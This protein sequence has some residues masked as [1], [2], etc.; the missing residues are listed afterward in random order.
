MSDVTSREA[1]ATRLLAEA[2]LRATVRAAGQD[3]EVAAIALPAA[4][5]PE[6]AAHAAAI[7]AL[8]FRYIALEIGP[9]APAVAAEPAAG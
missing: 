2:G 6:A 8:G 3:A 1:A 7:R 9:A 5:L 4:R